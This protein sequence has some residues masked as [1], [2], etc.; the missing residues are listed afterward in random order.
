MSTSIQA[1]VYI[2]LAVF[3]LS[4][5]ALSEESIKLDPV[6]VTSTRIPGTKD[7]IRKTTKSQD[8][9]L[10]DTVG[11]TSEF[12]ISSFLNEDSLV[13][14]RTRG[15]FAVQ[16]D[17]SLRGAPFEENLVLFNSVSMNDPKSGH[18]N[19][20]LPLTLF[21]IEKIQITYGSSSGVYG[22]GAMGGAINIIPRKP[23]K[24]LSME[25]ILSVGS[26]EFYSGGVSVNIPLGKIS[27]RSSFTWQRS[28][29]YARDTDFSIVTAS[30]Y[31][32][33][34][35]GEEKGGVF[36]GYLTKDF[37]AGSFYSE[38]YP[39]E[40][41]KIK[42]GLIL[43]NAEILRD[44]LV[45]K[46]ALYWRRLCDT[47]LLDRNRIGFYRNDH[48]TDIFGGEVSS[49]L[50]TP[51]GNLA[52][53][54]GLGGEKIRSTNLGDHSRA[55]FNSFLEYEKRFN[56]LH[57][58]AALR[59][60]YYDTFGFQVSPSCGLA[61]EVS[62]LFT[63]RCNASR[64]FRVP[65]FTELYYTSPA[66]KG[67]P[68]LGTEEAWSYDVGALYETK[69]I[70]LSG[71]FFLRTS[72]NVI[73]WTGTSSPGVWEAK[74]IGEF[75]IYG[76]EAYLQIKMKNIFQY[77]PLEKIILRY[78]F[79]ES[80]KKKGIVSKYVL[81]Y[82]KHN[83]IAELKSELPF[84]IK[85]RSLLTFRKRIGDDGYFVMD[86][87][88]YKEFD[89]K[90]GKATYYLKLNNVTNTAYEEYGYIKMPGFGV[91]FGVNIKF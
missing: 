17:I 34:D 19:M 55:K 13:D 76:T 39:A 28:A 87:V 82:L 7:G 5:E 20:D 57:I 84:G 10:L 66:N 74:N 26:W 54:F 8:T 47:F 11:I 12:S 75:D 25:G 71:S 4:G 61:Y 64:G 42:T 85:N 22:S 49:S 56:A 6:I 46:P 40:E 44:N 14:V 72:D 48:T 89:L 1:T 45:L 68:S 53:G 50:I 38:R 52:F 9:I 78:T 73:D 41:E 59:L 88:F 58:N 21:D 60:D 24:K 31:S 3:I 63:L 83:L 30:N 18:H 67:N 2:L 35:F 43:A 91:F 27:N 81:E 51:V 79:M 65:T 29:G 62:R 77:T 36:L 37:G 80:P 90:K 69:D 70:N 86:S 15:P 33:V 16:S 23:D 32:F